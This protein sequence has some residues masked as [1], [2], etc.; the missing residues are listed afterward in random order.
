MLV[1]KLEIGDEIFD[2][3]NRENVTI[4][5]RN[6]NAYT[7]GIVD[8]NPIDKSVTM[9]WFLKV[10]RENIFMDAQDGNGP[11]FA[12]NKKIFGD[13]LYFNNV[14]GFYMIKRKD[15]GIQGDI[16]LLKGTGAFPYSLSRNYD[17][18]SSMKQ[19]RNLE[20]IPE[21]F[22]R[23]YKNL[24]K[25]T[26]GIEYETCGGYIPQDACYAHGLIPL[27][28]G[29]ISGVEYATTVLDKDL[30]FERIVKQMELLNQY[31]AF[32]RNCSLHIHFGNYPVTREAIMA[33]YTLSTFIQDDILEYIPAYSFDTRHYKSSGKDYCKRLSREYQTF[34]DFYTFISDKTAYYAGSLEQD[35]PKDP[36]K[37]SKWQV[38]SRY[39]WLNFVNMCFYKGP[40]T[41]EFRMLRPTHNSN[42]LIFWIFFFNAMMLF[43]EKLSERIAKVKSPFILTRRNYKGI[44]PMLRD[45]YPKSLCDKMMQM[46]SD[47]KYTVKCQTTAQDLYGSLTEFEDSVLKTSLLDNG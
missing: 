38:K 47:L 3:Y 22:R 33:L 18:E 40:K 44:E 5:N 21:V 45:V 15:R 16:H 28:D 25:Y 10:L 11:I 31:T 42:K 27:R 8:Y 20:D 6:K 43:A 32:D 46:L 41:V 39:H 36:H 23:D 1:E 2:N 26:F 14:K 30:G 34:E 35:H 29:S 4:H 13:D 9:G 7:Y 12:I 17:A 37:E 19:F 24:I